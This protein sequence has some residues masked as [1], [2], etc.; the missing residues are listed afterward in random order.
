MS[1][2]RRSS[3]LSNAST[4]SNADT[5]WYLLFL[6]KVGTDG[7]YGIYENTQIRIKSFSNGIES[8]RVIYV[9]GHHGF[10]VLRMGKII[11]FIFDFFI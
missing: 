6:P 11:F 1:E 5:L 3:R 8:V 9:P 4:S 2:N 7:S 10:E